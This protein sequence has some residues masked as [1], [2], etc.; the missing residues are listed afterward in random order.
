M[1]DVKKEQAR[2]RQVSFAEKQRELGRKKYSWWMTP[3]EGEKIGVQIDQ[4]RLNALYGKGDYSHIARDAE[5]K[6]S[7]RAEEMS[8]ILS[9]YD[10][11]FSA[12]DAA[13]LQALDVVVA[14]LKDELWP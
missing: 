9:A 3:A 6:I 1:D 5:V 2:L 11:G 12:L 4:M 14:K 7:I 10:R 8:A 13:E